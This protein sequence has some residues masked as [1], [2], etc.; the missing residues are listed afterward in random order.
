MLILFFVSPRRCRC[1]AVSFSTDRPGLLSPDEG[2]W[3]HQRSQCQRRHSRVAGEEL[4]SCS[5]PLPERPMNVCTVHT[6]HDPSHF[7][8]PTFCP[9]LWVVG[10]K[11]NFYDRCCWVALDVRSNFKK[12]KEESMWKKQSSRSCQGIK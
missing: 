10:A 12:K 11:Y 6:H 4:R 1:S 9:C 3:S 8:H 7:F 2:K 5:S